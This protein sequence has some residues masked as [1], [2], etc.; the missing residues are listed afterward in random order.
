MMCNKCEA[1]TGSLLLLFGL[2]FLLVDLGVWAFWG[3]QWYTVVFLLAGL[4]AICMG[5]CPHC[6]SVSMPAPAKKARK[7]KR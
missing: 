6:C 3:I 2:A 7:R 4:V 1:M 5:K